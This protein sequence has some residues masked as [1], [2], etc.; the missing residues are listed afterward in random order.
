MCLKSIG[1]FIWYRPKALALELTLC[2]TGVI[3]AAVLEMGVGFER[4][5][6]WR[7]N[8]PGEEGRSLWKEGLA[9][10]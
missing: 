1:L 2:Q 9:G 6:A 5:W 3:V 4:G 7:V 8:S 10:V